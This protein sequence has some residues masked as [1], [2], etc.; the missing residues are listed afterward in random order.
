MGISV[1]KSVTDY[2]HNAAKLFPDKSAV[3]QEEEAVTFSKLE[4]QSSAM[5]VF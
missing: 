5:R 4:R 3:V 1:L 2:L